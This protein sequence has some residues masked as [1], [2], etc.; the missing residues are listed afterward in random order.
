MATIGNGSRLVRSRIRN[1]VGSGVDSGLWTGLVC[2]RPMCHCMLTPPRSL[3]G[4]RAP[5]LGV[6][7]PVCACFRLASV[8]ISY[9]RCR[10]GV[11]ICAGPAWQQ[12]A[13]ASVGAT[14]VV[15]SRRRHQAPFQW[16][17]Q[18]EARPKVSA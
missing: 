9:T 3:S 15:P 17:R 14:A 10:K 12:R 2:C 16:Q 4:E 8:L 6:L 11:R 1:W 13:A 5:E 7:H 18:T